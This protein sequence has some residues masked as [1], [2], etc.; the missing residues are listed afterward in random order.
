MIKIVIMSICIF[1]FLYTFFR[2]IKSPI[3]KTV[4]KLYK[5]RDINKLE[6][7]LEEKIFKTQK[8]NKRKTK[9]KNIKGTKLSRIEKT[10]EKINKVV[11]SKNHSWGYFLFTAATLGTAVFGYWSGQ[12]VN[13]IGV[14]FVLAGVGS[15]VP[16]IYLNYRNKKVNRDKDRKLLLVMGNITNSY[17]E[18][19]SFVTA[20]NDVLEN[21]PD[22]LYKYF[23]TFVD[24]IEY[25]GTES[26]IEEAQILANK[27][28]N[29]FFYEFMQMA[30]QAE[31]G[32][33]GLKY[34]MKSVPVDYQ[35]YLQKNEKYLNKVE[36][37]NINFLLRIM[38]F[39]MIIGFIKSISE[40]Y[41]DILVNY[42][43]GKMMLFILVAG[44]AL[45]S[46]LFRRY[47]K[48]IKLEI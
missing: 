27:I 9:I 47:N 42:P 6:N 12:V 45:A 33:E 13:N 4:K 17:M 37:Y 5:V 34:T 40:D 46:F 29:Y 24:A 36:K 2:D 22:P 18:K 23:K 20:V 10:K 26:F 32:E 30:I 28:N 1:F 38:L 48:D 41:Y 19:D 8:S 16:F 15:T 35:K 39:P 43:A 44:Y 7:S 14:S 21:I 31:E 11:L 3:K 25:F